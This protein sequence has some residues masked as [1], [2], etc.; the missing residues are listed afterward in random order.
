MKGRGRLL[1]THAWLVYVFLYAPIAILVLFSFNKTSQT[2]VWQGFTLEWYRSL[3]GNALILTAVRNSLVVGAVATVIAT[4]FGTLAAL[5]LGRY[6]FRGKGFTRNLLYLPIIIPEIVVGAALVTFF[7]VVGLRLSLASVVI[8]HVVF[9]VSYVAIVVRARL[10]G[11]DRSLEEAALD[12]GARPV[13]TFWRVTLP[14]V[15]PGIVSGA[16]LV[17]TVSIDDYVI[18]SFV[19]G[20]GAT[21][22]PLQIYSM[23]KVGVTPEVNA[24]STLLLVLTIVLITVAQ[25]LQHPPPEGVRD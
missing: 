22:L 1:R 8:A 5:A 2:A 20:V 17:F 25:W 11:F 23:L 24:V 18:T 7:G 10:S 15:L 14:L 13:Q 21:T 9:S 3:A 19:A 12:L 6:E 16:L 4:V